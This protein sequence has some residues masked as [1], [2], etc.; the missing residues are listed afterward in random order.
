V[1]QA[2]EI[3]AGEK[4]TL[5]WS[6]RGR[7]QCSH[8]ASRPGQFSWRCGQCRRWGTLRMETGI[9]PPP[10][11]PRDRRASPRSSRPDALLGAAPDS[12]LP[13]ATLDIGLTEDELARSGTRRSLLDRVGGWFSGVWR[14]NP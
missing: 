1:R 11:T 3:L 2:L 7:W 4:G 10:V 13:S 6:L 8:C 14:R 5:A 9:E 12:G